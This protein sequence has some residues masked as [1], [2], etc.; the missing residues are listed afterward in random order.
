M[1]AARYGH[2]AVVEHLLEVAKVDP[3][4]QNKDN[5]TAAD[6]A[7]FWGST[8][9]SAVFDRL[10]PNSRTTVTIASSSPFTSTPSPMAAGAGVVATG[11]KSLS[12]SSQSNLADWWKKRTIQE[13]KPLHFT[14]GI[15]N[16]Y[17]FPI[18]KQ[19]GVE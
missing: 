2:A 17:V 9:A 7:E 1:F 14:G 19:S 6:L 3:M 5:K 10:A 12:S 18:R 11:S 13:N 4:V 15:H 16:R 8:E